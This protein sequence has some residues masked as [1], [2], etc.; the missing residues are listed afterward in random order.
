MKIKLRYF[1][2]VN[3]SFKVKLFSFLKLLIRQQKCTFSIYLTCIY[4]VVCSVKRSCQNL[5][6]MKI[7]ANRSQQF[8][9]HFDHWRKPFCLVD[10]KILVQIISSKLN[11]H[12]W[13]E[14][15]RSFIKMCFDVEQSLSQPKINDP[16]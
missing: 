9:S 1:P 14:S 4:K 10:W 15:L 7:L 6:I 5:L 3:F 13:F 16:K 12:R 2:I 8:V 11:I